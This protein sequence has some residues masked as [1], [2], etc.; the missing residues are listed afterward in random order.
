MSIDNKRRQTKY[1]S[2]CGTKLKVFERVGLCSCSMDLCVK[3]KN[4]SDHQ[5]VNGRKPIPL[6]PKVDG[7]KV[8]VI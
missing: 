7:V 6:P 4:R 8:S 5:C 3:H 1:C 2:I